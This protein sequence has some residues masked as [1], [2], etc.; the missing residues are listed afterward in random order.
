MKYAKSPIVILSFFTYTVV[1]KIAAIIT[2]YNPLHRG[3]AYQL[4]EVRRRSGADSIIVL[5]S[6]DYVQRGCPAIFDKF[7]RA[8]MALLCGADLVLELPCACA[9]A[10]APRFAQGAVA[11]L[12]GLGVV[13]QLWFGS[14]AGQIEPFLALADLLSQ[15]PACYRHGLQAALSEGHSFPKARMLALAAC[16]PEFN[17]PFATEGDLQAFLLAPNNILG[18]AYCQ[19]LLQTG[20]NIQPK[21]LQRIGSGYHSSSLSKGYSSATA[22]RQFLLKQDPTAIQDQVPA[23]IYPLIQ[24]ACQANT[25]L[26]EDDF[27]LPLRYQLLKET[28]SSLNQYLDLP[29][30]LARRILRLQNQYA[31]FSQFSL[32]LKTRND[33]LTHIQRALLHILLGIR[34][35]DAAAACSP[36]F[37]RILGL[38]AC[39]ELLSSI[40]KEGSLPLVSKPGSLPP[41]CYEKDLFASNLYESLKAQKSHQ[42][43]VHEYSR[44]LPILRP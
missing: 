14:E 38:G 37:A 22:I 41:G 29:R 19:A 21:T 12:Q 9:A 32:L 27:S 18:L 13:D 26:Q 5:M 17:L 28:E 10:S 2:E 35:Q 7:L 44:P 43:F 42:P 40:K 6:G 1:M 23:R 31:S 8:E 4:E 3:H 36:A 39:P 25:C 20:S 15:E 24:R 16:L 34:P 33:T 30:D 11:L